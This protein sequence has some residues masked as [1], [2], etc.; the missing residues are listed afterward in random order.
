MT[1]S[2]TV[3]YTSDEIK[4]LPDESNWGA[5]AAMSDEEIAR[6]IASDPDEA[7]LGDE[8]MDHGNVIHSKA[9]EQTE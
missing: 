7:E 1:K 8:W 5:N 4:R 9:T 6:S 2:Q 3:K